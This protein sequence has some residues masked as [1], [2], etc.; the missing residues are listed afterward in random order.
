MTANM[1]QMIDLNAYFRV[2]AKIAFNCL[3]ELRGSE[4][5][6]QKKFDAIR[7][8][9]LTGE[10]ID[11]VVS[12][13][14]QKDNHM[15]VLDKIDDAKTFGRWR[16]TILIGPV[17]GGLVANVML[18]GTVTPMTVVLSREDCSELGEMDGIVC[19]WENRRELRFMEYLVE[20]MHPGR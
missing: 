11:Q 12:M 9:I 16:H 8:A 10:G 17:P 7:N 20:A 2:T 19:D 1:H 5:V 14:E 6:M 3:A 13:Q 18:Y 15:D 4:Y